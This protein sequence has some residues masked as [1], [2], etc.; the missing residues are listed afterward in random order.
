MFLALQTGEGA[1]GRRQGKTV[2]A[3]RIPI[4]VAGAVGVI[5]ATVADDDVLVLIPVK[6]LRGLRAAVDMETLCAHL[7][8][9]SAISRTR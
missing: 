4:G 9:R 5:E 6:L 7:Q 8:Q 1:R 3:V 2:G